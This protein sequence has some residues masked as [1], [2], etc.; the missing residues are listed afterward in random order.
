[1]P[2]FRDQVAAGQTVVVAGH[3]FGCGSSRDVAVN[4]LLGAG[5][6]CV[7]ARSFSFIYAR[8]QPNIGLLG[9]TMEDEEF[10]RLAQDGVAISVDM[11]RYE[12][13]CGGRTFPFQLSDMER[14]LIEAG[15]LTEAFKS[16][17]KQVFDVLCKPKARRAGSGP[18][19]TD[20]EAL[21]A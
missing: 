10:Y 3:G 17:G 8:N 1:M 4:A 11:G 2:S 7:I 5:V 16:F 14:A 6:Q 12:I 13:H 9:I 18:K 20:I 21:A 19:V 15:G